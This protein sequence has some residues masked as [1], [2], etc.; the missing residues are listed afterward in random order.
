M[1]TL[2][3]EALHNNIIFGNTISVYF[4]FSKNIWRRYFMSVKSFI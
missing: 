3:N 4:L 1:L 2:I